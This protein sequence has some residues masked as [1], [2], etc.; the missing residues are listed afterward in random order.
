MVDSSADGWSGPY[1]GL[2]ADSASTYKLES[3]VHGLYTIYRLDTS[4]TRTSTSDS[5]GS[6]CSDF[7]NCRYVL[8]T[9]IEGADIKYANEEIDDDDS[10][11]SGRVQ[12]KDG[13]LYCILGPAEYEG[14]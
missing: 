13:Y 9:E 8:A 5:M 14:V 1:T 7:Q 10:L 2:L 6:A 12:E 3:K 11:I 4:T